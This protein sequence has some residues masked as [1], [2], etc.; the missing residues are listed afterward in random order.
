MLPFQINSDFSV[1][2]QRMYAL[3]ERLFPICRSITGNGLR[4]T[5]RILQQEIPLT[6]YEVPTGTPAFDW[7]VPREWNIRDA[8]IKNSPGEKIVDFQQNN[9][10]ILNYSTP[11]NA[12]MSLEELRPHLF[13]L[14]EKPEWIPYRTSYFNDNW[15]FC[16]TQ[17][18]L[19]TM[20]NDDYEV[21][22]DSSLEPGALSYGELTIPGE[23]EEQILLFAHCCHPSLANDNLSGIAVIVELAKILSASLPRF[24]YRCIFAPGTIGCIAWLSQ[25]KPELNKV[26]LGLVAA[27]LGDPGQLTY[28]KTCAGDTLVDRA[29]LHVLRHRNI[30][31][32]TL[33]FSP[34]GYDERQFASPGINLPVG[35]LTRTPNGAYP[36]YHTSADNMSL[37]TPDAMAD[38][39]A[40]YYEVIA[41]IENNH[42]YQSNFPYCEPQLGKRGLYRKTGGHANAEQRELALLWVLNQAD[43]QHDLLEIAER[44]DIS[45]TAI[46]SAAKELVNANVIRI[47]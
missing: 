23:S 7:I 5:L 31:F 10:H 30:H 3:A 32:R 14:P 26:K 39:L 25:N 1:L 19:E 33:E 24:T 36:E 11:I 20:P 47:L 34:Y 43:G 4:E 45:F 15:G 21:V 22:I 8:Y 44:A 42:V 6:L 41:L 46:A 29:V 35:R 37:I 13:S 12:R 40:A 17:R 28:K 38:S 9:L 16:I 18:Q 27:V 2:G